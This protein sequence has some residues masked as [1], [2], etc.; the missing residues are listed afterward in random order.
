M[1]ENCPKCGAPDVDADKCPHCGVIIPLYKVALAKF[2][3]VDPPDLPVSL[4]AISGAEIASASPPEPASDGP[5]PPARPPAASHRLTF[6]GR[7]GTLFGIHLVNVALSL[8]TLGVFAFWGKVRV[9]RYLLAQSEFAGDRFAYH[10]TGGELLLGFIKVMGLFFLPLTLLQ[11]AAVLSGSQGAVTIAQL[12]TS[13]IV[14]VFAPVAIVGARRYRLG[15]T[16]W[17]GIRFGFDGEVWA[18]VKLFLGASVLMMLTLGFYYPVYHARSYGF[19][20]AHSRFGARPFGYDG[21]ARASFRPYLLAILLAVPT[22][23]LSVFWYLAWR[24]RYYWG[25][26]MFEAA[27]FR[28][29]VTGGQLLGLWAVNIVLLVLTLGLAWPWVRVRN[30]RFTFATLALEGP[31]ALDAIVQGAPAGSATGD[32]LSS[33]VGAGFEFGA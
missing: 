32:A 14:V 20:I 16:S 31:L 28:C 5:R 21:V 2:R 29:T 22:L 9:R 6:H 4:P 7:G 19:L 23:G 18:Y 33:F 11:V 1:A 17:R 10:G 8:V 30:A 3:R 26:T 12:V 25:H 15:R 24:R 13:L 27:R